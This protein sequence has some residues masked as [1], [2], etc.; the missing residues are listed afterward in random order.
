MEEAMS[1]DATATKFLI[2]GFPRNQDN[3]EGWERAMSDKVNMLFVL[4]FD[5]TEHVSRLLT[6][7]F[8]S[9]LCDNRNVL[10]SVCGPEVLLK[11]CVVMKFVDDDDDVSCS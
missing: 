9:L 7:L 4:F 10:L 8:S 2:D 5:C 11:T 6:C 3:L 1:R